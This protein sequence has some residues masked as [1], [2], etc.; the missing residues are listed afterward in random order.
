MKS[1]ASSVTIF[2]DIEIFSIFREFFH[3]TTGGNDVR[4]NIRV[5]D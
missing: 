5:A 3:S 2:V 4:F 1:T